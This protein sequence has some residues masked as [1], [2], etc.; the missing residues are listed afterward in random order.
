MKATISRSTDPRTHS[1]SG[2]DSVD[3]YHR[4]S[5]LPSASPFN[6]RSGKTA[7]VRYS[8]GVAATTCWMS[9]SASSILPT[10]TSD[11]IATSLARLRSSALGRVGR[12]AG[13]GEQAARP[14]RS[15]AVRKIGAST[16]IL[17]QSQIA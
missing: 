3:A 13:A 4:T 16:Q 11:D 2:R 9:C 6:A 5:I 10:T 1:T 7:I 14:A 17:S 8:P 15:S 12:E